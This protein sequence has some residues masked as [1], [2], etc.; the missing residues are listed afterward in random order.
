M[1]NLTHAAQSQPLFSTA[2]G[3]RAEFTK[4]STAMPKRK[5]TL[6]GLLLSFHNS[7]R[8]TTKFQKFT[9][10]VLLNRLSFQVKREHR[11][12]S[13]KKLKSVLAS[14]I[15]KLTRKKI[16]ARNNHTAILLLVN[17]V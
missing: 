14:K 2:H 4:I 7:I 1:Y 13:I 6:R 11:N 12:F 8:Y 16:G 9:P 3:V 15:R 10:S 5:F 17:S